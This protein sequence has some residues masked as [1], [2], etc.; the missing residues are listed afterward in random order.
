MAGRRRPK[1]STTTVVRGTVL[2][3]GNLFGRGDEAGGLVQE[4]N[5]LGRAC[6]GGPYGFI[7][8]AKDGCPICDIFRVLQ[9]SRDLQLR[10]EVGS[11]LAG[12]GRPRLHSS[13]GDPDVRRPR[14]FD[15]AERR[16]FGWR[17]R[18]RRRIVRRSVSKND[19]LLGGAPGAYIFHLRVAEEL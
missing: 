15:A 7:V 1:P 12:L 4:L 3:S 8:R 6:S 18:L 10:A 5:G 17:Q 2:R 14:S 9:P 11:G 19:V 13:R 16:L